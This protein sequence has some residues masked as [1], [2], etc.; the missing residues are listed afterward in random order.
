[1]VIPYDARI[2]GAPGTQLGSGAQPTPVVLTVDGT[3][4]YVSGPAARVLRA[5][6][7]VALE[8][9]SFPESFSP[10]AA[11][12]LAAYLESL[13]ELPAEGAAGTKRP[14]RSATRHG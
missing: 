1:M 14:L 6:R 8:G 7:Q 11:G 3:I 10:S 2:P 12:A 5:E 9:L 4:G 13:R